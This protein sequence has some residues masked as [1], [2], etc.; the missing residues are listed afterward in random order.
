MRGNGTI[1]IA[2]NGIV[3]YAIPRYVQPVS[4]TRGAGYAL[5]ARAVAGRGGTTGADTAG[6]RQGGA[7]RQQGAV[8]AAAL[9]GRVQPGG[10]AARV[11]QAVRLADQRVR[12]LHR[13][14]HEGRP[15]SWGNRAAPLRVVDLCYLRDLPRREAALYLGVTVGALEERL[16]RA[17]RQLKLVL[18]GPLR[19]DAEAFGLA[20]DPERAFSWRET[21][22][23]C[24]FWGRHRLRRRVCAPGVR[25]LRVRRTMRSCLRLLLGSCRWARRS[26]RAARHRDPAYV[27]AIVTIFLRGLRP[28]A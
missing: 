7:G 6:V 23:W 12:L 15:R 14:A 1:I 5:L 24:M 26:V 17:R 4:A 22:E 16:R 3:R 13:R 11:G 18:N 21:R 19:A 20:V 9:G 10:L 27:E 25:Y 8:R 28:E 2:K